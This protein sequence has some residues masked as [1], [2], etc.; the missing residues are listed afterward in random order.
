MLAWAGR[1]ARQAMT[2]GFKS[3]TAPTWT[4]WRR[5]V[6]ATPSPA[7]G[8]RPRARRRGWMHRLATLRLDFPPAGPKSIRP[9]TDDGT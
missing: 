7:L 4:V 6:C 5:R 2:P 3:G 8:F 9:G 1:E